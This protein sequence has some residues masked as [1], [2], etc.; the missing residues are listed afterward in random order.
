MQHHHQESEAAWRAAFQLADLVRQGGRPPAA[1]PSIMLRAGEV[2]HGSPVLDC[3]TFIAMDVEYTTGYVWGGGLI[4]TAVGLGVSAA[5]NAAAKSRAERKARAQWRPLGPLPVV[6]TNQ[7]VLLLIQHR[8]NSFEYGEIVAI[9]L[10]VPQWTLVLTFEGAPPVMLRGPWAP[11]TGVVI[12]ASTLG[13]PWP[14]GTV[15]PLP[16]ASPPAVLPGSPPGPRP[17]SPPAPAPAPPRPALPPGTA[18]GPG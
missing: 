1:P 15:L 10:D 3:S 17:A 16:Q 18:A 6:V 7:R 13:Q 2:Q 8:W 12:A 5:A 4:G 9:Q 14:P 11:W